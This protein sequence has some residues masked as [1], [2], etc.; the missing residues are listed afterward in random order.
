MTGRDS[1]ASLR[2]DSFGSFDDVR[3]N[4][5]EGGRTTRAWSGTSRAPGQ[6]MGTPGKVTSSLLQPARRADRVRVRA[7][8]GAALAATPA[9]TIDDLSTVIDR[10]RVTASVVAVAVVALGV[11]LGVASERGRRAR[12]VSRPATTVPEVEPTV[13]TSTSS[14]RVAPT[15]LRG[16]G[17][18]DAVRFKDWWRPG[19]PSIRRNASEQVELADTL[20]R[21][22]PSDAEAR[23]VRDSEARRERNALSA[24]SAS[25]LGSKGRAVRVAF[26]ASSRRSFDIFVESSL[27]DPLALET[28][29][30]ALA[31]LMAEVRVARVELRSVER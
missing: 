16:V 31:R 19:D 28:L 25:V 29:S 13:R 10:T 3:R 5:R 21:F 22:D 24:F 23:A 20:V 14:P 8:S 18:I 12:T 27:D 9:T 6:R 1:A 30:T 26:S 11:A 15:E 4:L 17:A 7:T 2:P